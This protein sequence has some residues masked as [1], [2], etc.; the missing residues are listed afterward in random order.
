MNIR[1]HQS[2]VRVFYKS[3]FVQCSSEV[4]RRVLKT[5]MLYVKLYFNGVMYYNFALFLR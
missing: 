2:A 1:Q 4:W 3:V 5:N